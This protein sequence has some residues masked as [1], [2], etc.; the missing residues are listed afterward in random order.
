MFD[1]IDEDGSSMISK[2]ELAIMNEKYNIGLS[3]SDIDAM[4]GEI[5]TDGQKVSKAELIRFLTSRT[6]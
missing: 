5:S 4:I 6:N 1:L 3:N 2:K